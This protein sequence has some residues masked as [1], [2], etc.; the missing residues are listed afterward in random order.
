MNVARARHTSTLLN[1]G[2]VLVA[3]G[4]DVNGTPLTSAELYNPAT[5]RWSL[6]GSMSDGRWGGTATLLQ[7]GEVLVAGGSD[8][9]TTIATAELF[10]PATGTWTLTGSLSR[11]R[12]F[13]T[14]TLLPNGQV[15]VA[16]GETFTGGTALGTGEI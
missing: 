9:F 3:G 11:P 13:H 5:R 10:N 7:N 15:L 1:T 12:I 6:T 14:A 4:V 16:G 8:Q 2:E